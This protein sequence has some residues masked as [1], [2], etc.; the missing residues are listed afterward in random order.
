MKTRR[1][2]LP[3]DLPAIIRLD[4]YLNGERLPSNIEK[5]YS[6]YDGDIFIG[7]I[8]SKIV[9]LVS[10]STDRWDR[11]AIIDHLAVDENYRGKELG[12]ELLSC[13]TKT[14]INRGTRILCVQTATWNNDAIRF[15]RRHGFAERGVF[16]D[17]IGD[18]NDMIWLDK[19]LA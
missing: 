6:D 9:G 3:A 13:V 10:L 14:A 18:G 4:T 5:E 1:L 8:D 2:N 17:Y 12:S 19:K 15:Y 7:E 16:P 11:V